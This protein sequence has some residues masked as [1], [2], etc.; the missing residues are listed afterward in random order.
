MPVL[1]RA[2]PEDASDLAQV[3][4]M[5]WRTA[6]RGILPGRFLGALTPE[7]LIP[8]WQERIRRS[9]ESLWVAQL[10]PHV[11]GY[12][13]LGSSRDRDMEAGFAGELYEL[14]VHPRLQGRGLGR[15]LLSLAWELL[16]AQ[17]HRWGTLWVLEANRSARF[18]YERAGLLAD[19][20]RSILHVGGIPVPA[21][22]Y[23]RALNPID[24]HALLREHA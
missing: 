12:V 3:E 16:A 15:E 20:R 5:A 18:F 9:Q 22:R 14:Y 23:A 19:G 7:R 1:R 6:Y 13:S 11:V 24:L 4:A 21:V 17:G 8:R 2:R 10:G